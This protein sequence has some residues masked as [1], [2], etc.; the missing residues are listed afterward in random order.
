MDGSALPA[1]SKFKGMELYIWPS[2]F[3]LPSIESKCLQFMACAKFCAAP[4]TVIPSNSPWKC[5]KGTYPV[6]VNRCANGV[7]E[8]TEFDQ[9]AALLRKSAQDVVLDNELTLAERCELDA[10]SS[11]MLH[12]FYPA[13]LHLL[14]LDQWNY[15]TVT[16]HWYSSQLL[17]PYGLYYLERRRRRAQAYVAACARS[18]SQLIRDAIMAINLLSAKLGDSKYFYGDKP[19]S[20]DALVF[21]Y[22]APMLKLPLPSDR[23]QQHIMGCPN[24]VRFIESIISI[25]LPLT[26][27]QIRLQCLS[28]DKWQM[29]RARAQKSAERMNM[30]RD[31][32]DEEASAPI[33]DTVIFAVGALTLS[34][35][36]AVHL[37]II[38]VS[39]EEEAPI[40][41]D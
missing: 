16:A 17:F 40:E 12:S 22:L 20:L 33:R 34:I 26:E 32:V 11:L 29:R 7:V 3:G 10:F 6:F 23:L 18:E 31:T 21:G 1:E 8:T 4:V 37:G 36:F 19:S 27:N 30:R 24:L 38:S 41:I 25:Y 28:K 2:D 39:V 5:K 9:F 15:T 35:L 13:Q 14:W